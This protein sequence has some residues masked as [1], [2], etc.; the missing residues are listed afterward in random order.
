[1]ENTR[2]LHYE[3]GRLLGRGGM[4]EVYEALDTR[5]QRRVALK[6]IAPELS[7]D[8][9]S[10]R[11]FEREALSAAALS[12]PHI[13][14]LYALEHDGRTVFIAMELMSGESLR[15]KL[16]RGPLA[17]PEAL[18]LARDVAAALAHAHRRGVVHRDV[19][20]ENLMFDEDGAIKVMDFGLARA[21]QASRMTMTGSSLG[22]AAYMPPESVR[23]AVGPP[24]DVFALGVTLHE[25]LAGALP[26]A[27]ESPIAL[28]YMIANEAPRPLR[29]ARP[30]APPEVEALVLRALEKD[31]ERRIDAATL[32]RELSALTGVAAPAIEPPLPAVAGADVMPARRTEELEAERLP[33]RQA[34]EAL[35]PA[36]PRRRHPAAWMLFTA[37]GLAVS[38][39]GG[40]LARVLLHHPDD[41]ARRALQA[42]TLND[43]AVELLKDG[44]AAP[45]LLLLQRALTLDPHAVHVRLNLAQALRTQGDRTRAAETFAAVARDTAAAPTQRAIGF[46]GLADI[47]MDDETWTQ[48]ADYLRQGYALD[49]N[50]R[51]VS[52]LGYALVR[53]ARPGEALALLRRALADYPGSAALHKNAGFALLQLDSL[54]AARAEAERALSLDP[55]FTPA[56]GLRARIR[57]RQK[58]G[59][60]ARADWQAFLAAHP[61][62]AD[63][64]EVAG[65]LR[66]AGAL[67]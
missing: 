16:A 64:A 42:Q 63:S 50:E 29:E 31:P 18:A 39:G 37:L 11:R 34:E 7:A 47:A 66:A 49:P 4:G 52:Q 5:L 48:A 51:S 26:F 22:T 62:S 9:E 65:A 17:V 32:A 58:D 2:I 54:G 20:P 55:A 45:A 59:Q 1:M 24:A 41:P 30:D 44:A 60:G 6:F 3:V 35:V 27:G 46:G 21:A 33:A 43:Q 19:K 15:G 67:P 38:I 14:T 36:G 25:M 8:A 28:L 61:A 40:L 56:L 53:A 12:H 57:A 10:E 13:A 23:G